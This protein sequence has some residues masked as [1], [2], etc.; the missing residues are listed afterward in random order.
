[1]WNFWNFVQIIKDNH[2]FITMSF[3]HDK[4][5]ILFLRKYTWITF[6]IWL[7]AW[8]QNIFF[9]FLKWGNLLIFFGF[10]L[11]FQRKPGIF[12]TK[13][14]CY[15]VSLQTDLKMKFLKKKKN[16]CFWNKG[17]VF[18]IFSWISRE[19]SCIFNIGSNLTCFFLL[20]FF[21]VLWVKPDL[22]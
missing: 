8:K 10:F 6:R 2:K 15:S 17:K 20:S 22:A 21:L 11:K 18:W 7:Y 19:K 14:I 3:L 5:A 13:S 1:L 9:V 4:K 16:L 12:N